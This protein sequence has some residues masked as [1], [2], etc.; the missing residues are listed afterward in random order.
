[1]GQTNMPPIQLIVNQ[2][3]QEESA[4]PRLAIDE[5]PDE[6][7]YVDPDG[8][9]MQADA[10]VLTLNPT[11]DGQ[12][13]AS[14]QTMTNFSSNV[15]I[16]IVNNDFYTNGGPNYVGVTNGV[17]CGDML[18]WDTGENKWLVLDAPA[19]D[20]VLVFDPDA[21]CGSKLVWRSTTNDYQSL[22]RKADDSVD[23]DWLRAH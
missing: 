4:E 2:I 1:M 23:F 10:K 20:S 7:R 22:Q 9:D 17:T 5:V 12:H 18:Y 16:N 14:W 13:A 19:S 8:E 11:N 3:M 15:W 21:A 6:L